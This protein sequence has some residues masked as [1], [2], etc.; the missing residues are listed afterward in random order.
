MKFYL[1]SLFLCLTL[2]SQATNYYVDANTTSSTQNGSLANP[3]KTLSQVSSNQSSFQPGDFVL[4]K[5]G[6]TFTGTFYPTRGG[7]S[8][9]PLTFGAYGT[10]AKPKFTGTGSKIGYLFYVYDKSYITFRDLWI[11][12]PSIDNSD[13]SIDAKIQRA[14]TFDE[15]S[16]NCKIISCDIHLVGVAGYFI[17]GTHT[18]DSCD[19]GNLRMVVDTDQ[20]Y[21]PGND[22]DYGA[23]PLVISSANNTIT[24]NYFHDCW[25][26]SYDYD[27]DGGAIEFYGSGTNNNFIGYN[28]IYDC[29]GLSEITGNSANNTFAYNKMINNGSLF[30]FQSGATFSG[31][32]FY[33]NVVIEN[34]APR[35]PESRLIG[36]SLGASAVIMKNNVFH[37]TTGTDVAGSASGITHEDNIYK[38]SN[39]SVVGFTLG[40]SEMTTTAAIFTNT[41]ASSP[42]SW[43]FT[44]VSGSPA[45]DFGQNVGLNKDFAG[46]AVPAVPNSG[47]LETGGGT[48]PPANP[49]VASS[50]ATSIGCNG[51]TATV[52]VTA[53]GGTA[54]YSGT[55]TFT[56]PA[57]TYDFTVTDAAGGSATTTIVIV[58]PTP[59]TASVIAGTA[60]SQSGTATATVSASG[61]TPSY[62]Y[63]LDGG[64]YQSSSTFQ[65]VSVG[66]HNVTVRDGKACT[67]VKSF[68]ISVAGSSPLIITA[69]TG[70]ISCNGENTTVTISA[71]GGKAPYSGTGTFTVTAGTYTY[72]VT[73]AVG[74]TGTYSVTISEPSAIVPSLSATPISV[75]GGVAVITAS[76]TGGTAP[77][78]YQLG[79]GGFLSTNVFANIAAGTY[80]VTVKDAR[81]CTAVGSITITPN[82]SSSLQ[83]SLVSKTDN[84]CRWFWD[85]TI[86]VTATGGTAPYYYKINNYGYARRTTF[87]NL[88][89]GTYTLY[90]IDATGAVS[91]MQVTILASTV[92]CWGN[93]R[94]AGRAAGDEEA[95][96]DITAK[97]MDVQVFPNPTTTEF[98]MLIK[99]D[100]TEDASIVIMNINGQKVWQGKAKAFQKTAFGNNFISGMYIA[101]VTQGDYTQTIKLVKTK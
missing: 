27:Y 29:I 28:T 36:G 22:D 26:T 98:S 20:G 89:P 63:S 100:L 75:V 101:K 86:T 72:T 97:A 1:L 3:W 94:A 67:T 12:D 48:T 77:Y 38:L 50:T 43:N 73:D 82:T 25:A 30:Y 70:T 78:T 40:S 24:H 47:I 4:F 57:G 88:G 80:S 46:N 52:T 95:K 87:V 35:V 83:I 7:N 18:M 54:P 41:S 32:K 21:Q 33:N 23:N 65:G 11:T 2:V 90:A 60:S 76:A 59:L 81:G 39:N 92:S 79:T 37:L 61:G 51:G 44:P 31:Y 53:S 5:R 42:L 68:T 9:A 91:S 66:A 64:S 58:Q 6:C 14:F 10:G 85:G 56:K 71:A 16:S 93:N 45:I 34:A 13:R 96:T 19:V 15:S 17:G 74:T 49:I 69:V 84:S 99:S 62:T 8:S 55:G